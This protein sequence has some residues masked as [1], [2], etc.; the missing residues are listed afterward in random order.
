M[1]R[2]QPAA[3][4]FSEVEFDFK[5]EAGTYLVFFGAPAI[6]LSA[7]MHTHTF[8]NDATGALLPFSFGLVWKYIFKV[9]SWRW[10]V[11]AC[12]FPQVLYHCPGLKEGIKSLYK[13]S[14]S[15]A[16]PTG[17]TKQSEE[18]STFFSRPSDTLVSS[19][20]ISFN[21]VDSEQEILPSPFRH[22]S[23]S[24]RASTVW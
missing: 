6:V 23:S 4:V 15:N 13:L 16:K 10:H 12:L 20:L 22:T 17:E 2:A 5:K 11:N 14:T 8:I 21:F 7:C 24:L 9:P 18:V 19:I 3:Y 1:L